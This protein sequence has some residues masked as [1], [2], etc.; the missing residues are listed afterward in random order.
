MTTPPYTESVRWYI[1]K[2][3][4]EASAAQIEAINKAEVNNARDAYSR[5][6]S[7]K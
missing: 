3:I 4:V 1:A 7:S 2:Q 5:S 6:F